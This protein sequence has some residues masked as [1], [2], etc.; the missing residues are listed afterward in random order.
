MSN[1]DNEDMSAA[2]YGRGI[3]VVGRCVRGDDLSL[4]KRNIALSPN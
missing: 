1:R 3:W 4:G 2:R